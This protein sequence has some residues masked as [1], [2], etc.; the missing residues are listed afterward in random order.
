MIRNTGRRPIRL[1]NSHRIIDQILQIERFADW[2]SDVG[3][4]PVGLHETDQALGRRGD[5]PERRTDILGIVVGQILRQCR[6][7]RR[8]RRDRIHD[9]MGEHSDKSRPRFRLIIFHFTRN[10]IKRNDADVL[11][12]KP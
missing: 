11:T 8:D 2:G 12:V 7:Q 10:V 5:G 4:R 1:R 3:Q 9:F 6:T